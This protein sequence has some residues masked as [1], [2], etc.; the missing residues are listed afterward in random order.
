M[1][2]DCLLYRFHISQKCQ[3]P[4]TCVKVIA[5]QRWDVFW[6]MVYNGRILMTF[7]WRVKP[8]LTEQCALWPGLLYTVLQKRS[9]LATGS[10]RCA[11]VLSFTSPNGDSC[12]VK[13]DS[14]SAIK[15]YPV[16]PRTCRY[17]PITPW[18]CSYTTLWNKCHLMA[19]SCQWRGFA[20]SCS[21]DDANQHITGV[22]CIVFIFAVNHA[23][24]RRHI[25]TV[26]R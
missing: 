6:D 16:M 22:R 14:K 17:N 18:A 10:H 4:F 9:Q 2:F 23:L 15:T 11:A 12:H 8:T 20:S 24:R 19:R 26:I 7:C 25:S 3:N 1:S 5:S 13:P 21:I